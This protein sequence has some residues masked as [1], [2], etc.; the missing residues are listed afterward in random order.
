MRY[1]GRMHLNRRGWKR[2]VSTGGSL[3]KNTKV[4]QVR[5][6]MMETEF[7]MRKCTWR[8]G[9]GPAEV[10]PRRVGTPAFILH[11]TTEVIA[12]GMRCLP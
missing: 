1:W 7:G 11:Q 6:Y 9:Y 12:V 2:Q 8:G 5:A 3:S 4:E 10:S